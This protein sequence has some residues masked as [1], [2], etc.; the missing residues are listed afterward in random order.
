MERRLRELL[1]WAL[2]HHSRVSAGWGPVGPG[3]CLSLPDHCAIGVM[4]WHGATFV[5]GGIDEH[6]R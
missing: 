3:Q 2:W 6:R 1:R 4:A 5:P